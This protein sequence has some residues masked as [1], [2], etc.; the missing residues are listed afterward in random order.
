LRKKKATP[1]PNT[2]AA[3]GEQVSKWQKTKGERDDNRESLKHLKGTRKK[4]VFFPLSRPGIR[5]SPSRG[6]KGENQKSHLHPPNWS[7]ITRGNRQKEKKT[8]NGRER[9]LPTQ[10]R[11]TCA[12]TAALFK[13]V[14]RK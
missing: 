10:V 14:G 2:K 13:T 11:P 3:R 4:K 8:K 1:D 6:K 12:R 5:K 9:Q 7:P